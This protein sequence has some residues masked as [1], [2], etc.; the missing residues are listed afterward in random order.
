MNRPF[1]VTLTLSLVLCLTIWNVARAWTALAWRDV[2]N[3]FSVAQNPYI[4]ALSGAL[5]TITG[6]VLMWGIDRGKAWA[7]KMLLVCATLY[8]VWN[9]T[10]RLVWRKNA[11]GDAFA[12]LTGLVLFIFIIFTT[13]SLSGKK[14]ERKNQTTE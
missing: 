8:I 5:W 4:T 2:L 10:E 3:E 12:A 1:R 14:H 11:Q 6:I 7:G 13:K 9:W